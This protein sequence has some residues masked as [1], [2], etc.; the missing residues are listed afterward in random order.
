MV[1]ATL[2]KVK[3]KHKGWYGLLIK[4]E[5]QNLGLILAVPLFK[6]NDSNYDIKQESMA[7]LLWIWGEKAYVLRVDRINEKLVYRHYF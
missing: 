2:H 5:G 1:N 7:K 6:L 4:T 3:N